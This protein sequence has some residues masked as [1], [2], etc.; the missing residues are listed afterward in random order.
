MASTRRVMVVGAHV[1]DFVWRAAGAVALA[2]GRGGEAC[3]IALSYGERGESGDLWAQD[4]QTVEN[5]KAIRHQEAER[6]AERLGAGF[7]GLDLGDYPLIVDASALV[8]IAEQIRQFRPDVLITHTD[9]DPYNPDHGLAH[10]AVVRARSLAAGVGVP[11]A[12]PTVTPPSLLLFEPHQPETCNFCPNL[13]LDITS[14]FDRKR[15]AMGEMRA[16]AYLPEHYVQR[17]EQRA[18]Q[19]RLASGRGGDLRY[20]EAFQR[21]T[22]QVVTLP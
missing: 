10:A 11:S 18:H 21:V 6:A 15:A 3:V 4:G 14:V 17:A 12:F 22:P 7:V 19:A 1:A 9:T 5:V 13:F 16:Q 20:A 2:T 8:Q